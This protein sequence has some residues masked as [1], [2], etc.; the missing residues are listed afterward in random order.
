MERKQKVFWIGCG[1]MDEDFIYG[2]SG[3]IIPV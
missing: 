2:E 3:V 1:Q